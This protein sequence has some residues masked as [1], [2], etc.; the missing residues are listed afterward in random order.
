[1]L[2]AAALAL[3]AAVP[4][5]ALLTADDPAWRMESDSDGIA[6]YRGSLAGSGVV[7]VKA[8]MTVPGSI[9]EVSLVLEDIPRRRQWMGSRTESVL[10]ER[11][12]DYD[13]VEHLHVNMPWPVLDRT[14]LIR[15]TITV[16]DDRRRATITA[17][18]IDAH[19]ADT[20]PKLV[21][22]TVH[23]STFQMT[24]TP[25]GVEVV[26]LVFIDPGGSIPKW[27][28]NYFARRV[29]R[30]TLAGLR[31]QVARKLYPPGRLEAM[32]RRILAY[33]DARASAR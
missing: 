3:G 28:V 16:S 19:P 29:A 4:A 8:T 18:S 20:L 21:R 23:E 26:A 15:A 9:A 11:A 17:R 10:L 30:S 12:S 24:Q 22:A 1:V 32:R 13:Q 27:I 5:R 6:L 31:K 14:A 2:A 25:A 7:P 33:S